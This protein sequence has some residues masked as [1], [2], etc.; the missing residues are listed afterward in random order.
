MTSGQKNSFQHDGDEARG[1]AGARRGLE[2]NYMSLEGGISRSADVA[3]LR[4]AGAKVQRGKLRLPFPTL[5]S[6]Q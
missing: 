3:G 4:C 1:S 5:H 6:G 2:V